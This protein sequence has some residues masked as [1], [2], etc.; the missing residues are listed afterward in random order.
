[1]ARLGLP[2]SNRGFP[3][4]LGGAARLAARSGSALAA[5]ML[6]MGRL[7]T[8]AEAADAGL[9]V[10]AIPEEAFESR[11]RRI[12]ACMRQG[13]RPALARIKHA[14]QSPHSE[15]RPSYR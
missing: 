13:R 9:I 2:G 4:A 15:L 3:P 8:G 7:L 6:Y 14:M 11:L 5:R 10:E 1:N 12:V